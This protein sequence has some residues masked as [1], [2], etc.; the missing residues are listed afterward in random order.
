M[1]STVVKTAR[2]DSTSTPN[3]RLH[4]HCHVDPPQ[5]MA[6]TRCSVINAR[7]PLKRS[8]RSKP[9]VSSVVTVTALDCE[10]A[11]ESPHVVHSELRAQAS[12]ER[13]QAVEPM[14]IIDHAHLFD[15]VLGR[16]LLVE[17]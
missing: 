3:P 17:P 11:D 9:L 14:L 13:G 8:V 15:L 12:L 1:D 7:P 2:S 6:I 16:K 5:S 10:K 4:S